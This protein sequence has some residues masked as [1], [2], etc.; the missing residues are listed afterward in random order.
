MKPR[1]KLQRAYELAFHPAQLNAAW[2]DWEKGRVA[3][4]G[5]LRETVDWAWMLHQRLPEAPAA[6]ARALCRLARYQAIS[7]LYRLPSMLQRF[8]EKL[9]SVGK[10]PEEVPAWMVRDIGLPP[11]GRIQRQPGLPEV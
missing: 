10:A 6:S 2:N 11:F 7:R 8:R 5:L 9:G 1:E 4:P 3:D